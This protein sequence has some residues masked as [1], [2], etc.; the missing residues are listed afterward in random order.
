M[1]SDSLFSDNIGDPSLEHRIFIKSINIFTGISRGI[2]A[3]AS[4]GHPEASRAHT[5]GGRLPEGSRS[6][7]DPVNMPTSNLKMSRK[8]TKT[9]CLSKLYQTPILGSTVVR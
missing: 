4:S 8:R 2:P 5:G 3:M 1:L 9:G 7:T 6:E